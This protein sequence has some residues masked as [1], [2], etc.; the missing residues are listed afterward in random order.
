[1]A[2][3]SGRLF[4]IKAFFIVV[5]LAI[6]LRLFYWQ[7]IRAEE[8]QVRADNQHLATKTLKAPRGQIF[9]SDNSLLVSNRVS[10]LMYA[11]PKV[12]KDIKKMAAVLARELTSDD[13]EKDALK[14]KKED[15]E[16]SLS[17]DLY[18]VPL[19]KAIDLE[20]KKKIEALNLEGIGFEAHSSR[21][22]PESSSSA[23]LLGFVAEDSLG[24]QTGYFGIEGFYNG[25]LRGVEGNLIEEKD[26]KGLPILSGKFFQKE[27]RSGSSLVLTIDKTVQYITEQKLKEGMIKYGAKGASVIIMEPQTGN[28]LAM[29]AYPNYNPQSYFDFPKDSFKNPVVADAYE[30]GSTFKTLV[31][32]AGINENVVKADTQ[33]D[34]CSGPVSIGGFSIRTW[35]N[36]YKKNITMTET[37]IHS[38]NT[39]MVYVGRKLGLDKLYEYIEKFGFGKVTAVDLQDE[40]TPEIRPKKTW[41][42]VD[43][44]TVTFGQGI[45]ATPIQMVRA[46]ASIANGGRLMEPHIVKKIITSTKEIEINPKVV[47]NPITEETAKVITEMMVQAVEQGE[48][49]FLRPKG[50]KVAGKTGTAQI[51]V[52]GHYDPNKTI[53]SFVGF[54]PARNPKF[55]MLVRYDQPTSSIYGAETAAPT[56]F[57]IARELFTYYGISPEE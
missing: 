19:E 26:A 22:Y 21:F 45:A 43:V 36:K 14:S 23:H 31:M 16:Q 50:F 55:V 2:S 10:Y 53:A 29:A 25:E 28:I 17:Q 9:A 38:D 11:Q 20:M 44:A 49:K 40:T 13:P 37:I 51:P 35:N 3:Q 18:W 7:V 5:F 47:Q 30:P 1:M 52:A 24:R 48:A 32:A 54:A 42:E 56:F 27:A 34:D 46:V 15:L 33:C 57:A 6:T 12:I 4:L 8:L 41:K 39:G